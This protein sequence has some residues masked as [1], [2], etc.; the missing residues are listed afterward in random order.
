MKKNIQMNLCGRLYQIDEDAYELLQHYM[1]T[2]RNYFSCQEGGLEIAN[3]IEERVAELLDEIKAAGTIAITI[4]H[5]QDIIQRVGELEDITSEGDDEKSAKSDTDN[6]KGSR[7][8]DDANSAQSA[9]E[10]AFDR[11]L[12]GLKNKRY[13]NDTQNKFLCGVLSGCSNF[14][15]GDVLIW[16]IAFVLVSLAGINMNILSL[17]CIFKPPF[18]SL[19]FNFNVWPIILYIL[20]AILAPS[21]ETPEDRLK[22]KGIK[23]NPQTLASE[24]ASYAEKANNHSNE[25]RHNDLS[26]G[27]SQFCSVVGKMMMLFVMAIGLTFIIPFIIF[28][29]VAIAFLGAPDLFLSKFNGAAIDYYN[30]APEYIYMIGAG[31]LILLFIPAYCSLHYLLN[32]FKKVSAMEYWQ[33]VSW[34]LIWLASAGLIIFSMMKLSRIDYSV[35]LKQEEEHQKMLSSL[36]LDGVQFHN[37]EDYDF[38][39][40][41]GWK[42][43]HAEGCQSDRYTYSGQY[44]TG[45]TKVRYLDAAHN[46]WE[47]NPLLYQAEKTM[48]VEPGLYRLT[49]IARCAEQGQGVFI[50]ACSY[51]EDAVKDPKG[52]SAATAFKRLAEVPAYGNNEHVENEE[53]LSSFTT[54]DSLYTMNRGYDIDSAHSRLSNGWTVVAVDSIIIKHHQ[55]IHYG[56]CTIPAF[57]GKRCY[58]NWFSATDFQ[59]RKL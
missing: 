57:T 5:I 8:H 33:R 7:K 55:T 40:E 41:G 4:E 54:N 28:F 22:M 15:G 50:Y 19:F 21:A 37:Q 14:F 20:V 3:D 25:R 12:N 16:R 34:T 23:V 1:E 36:K 13:Y 24:V 44:Y 2:L 10:S 31:I 18:W 30:V 53:L 6:P 11:W 27:L 49:A 52:S 9:K 51:D 46:E 32:M 39:K 58:A 26:A 47:E 17:F 35:K 38:F 48:L 29:F 43:L 45:D 42:L 59:L 56:V